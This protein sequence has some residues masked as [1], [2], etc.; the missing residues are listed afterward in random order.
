MLEEVE[1]EEE[2]AEPTLSE[3][4][5]NARRVADL[6]LELDDADVVLSERVLA[7]NDVLAAAATRA[8]ELGAPLSDESLLACFIVQEQAAEGKYGLILPATQDSVL[9]LRQTQTYQHI[10]NISSGNR[11]AQLLGQSCISQCNARRHWQVLGR[12]C[13]GHRPCT[14]A[15]DL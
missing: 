5:A 12:L 10:V 7:A 8:A 6:L 2:Q 11:Y 14:A 3:R 15:T 13:H 9:D 4:R 1:E